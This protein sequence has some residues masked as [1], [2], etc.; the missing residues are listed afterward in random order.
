MSRLIYKIIKIFQT[1]IIIILL[2]YG[3]LYKNS[4]TNL[5]F[6]LLYDMQGLPC[7]IYKVSTNMPT[8]PVTCGEAN[9]LKAWKVK[10][11][12]LTLIV[13]H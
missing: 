6:R 5:E 9:Q 2:F 11:S 3:I 12:H 1:R 4:V 13:Q 10:D 8:Y 7:S